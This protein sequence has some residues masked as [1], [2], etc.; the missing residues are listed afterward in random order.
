MHVDQYGFHLPPHMCFLYLPTEGAIEAIVI[1]P[2]TQTTGTE[3]VVAVQKTWL[4]VLLM[5]QVTDEGM[6][7]GIVWIKQVIIRENDSSCHLERK[8]IL[9]LNPMSLLFLS[10]ISVRPC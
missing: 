3:D 8:Q 10:I 7:A 4:A 9:S 2:A 6:E 5:T 1:G